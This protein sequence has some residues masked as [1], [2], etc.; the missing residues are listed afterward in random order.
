MRTGLLLAQAGAAEVVA[1]T[2]PDR[3]ERIAQSIPD[4][5]VRVWA[6]LKIMNV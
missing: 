2:D 4:P 5:E 3:A 1:A 6:L